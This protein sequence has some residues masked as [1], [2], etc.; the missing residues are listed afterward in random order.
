MWP[1]GHLAV[2]YLGY[3][4]WSTA[5]KERQQPLAVIAAIIGSQFPDLID[6]P[7]AWTVPL[8]PSGRSLAHSLF[9]A[10]LVVTSLY[11]AAKRFNRKN[12]AAAFGIGYGTHIIGDLGPRV[13]IGLLEGDLTQLKWTTY[14]FWPL[15]PA[16]PYANDASFTNHLTAISLD[17]YVLAQLGLALAA[18]IVWFRSGKPG[19]GFLQQRY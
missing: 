14:L 12:A 1:W 11:Y 13:I 3:V 18:A 19:L 16:P 7:L 10:T 5:R 8:L 6:K 2:G 9:T 17:S 4:V 15:L